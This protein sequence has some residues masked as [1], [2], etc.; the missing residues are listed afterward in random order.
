MM[1][2]QKLVNVFGFILS[3]TCS[4]FIGLEVDITLVNYGKQGR[5][6]IYKKSIGTSILTSEKHTKNILYLMKTITL[7]VNLFEG[8][9][10]NVIKHQTNIA[11]YWTCDMSICDK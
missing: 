1:K 2:D 7:L 11:N 10:I 5:N 6:N 8:K 4:K 9:Q 3:S